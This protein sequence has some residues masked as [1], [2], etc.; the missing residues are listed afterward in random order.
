[1]VTSGVC[2]YLY[3]H[4][5]CNPIVTSWR[6]AEIES[7][8]PL[9]KRHPWVNLE[10]AIPLDELP[11]VIEK[12]LAVTHRYQVKHGYNRLLPFTVRPVNADRAGYLCPTKGK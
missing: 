2:K 9:I 4:L 12:L 8:I 5:P 3:R 11:N 10:Y 6:T 7:L 1:M